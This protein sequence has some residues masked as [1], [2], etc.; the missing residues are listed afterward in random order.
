[1]FLNYCASKSIQIKTQIVAH[2]WGWIQN[3]AIAEKIGFVEN[4]GA[5]VHTLDRSFH[6]LDR[7]FQ[8]LSTVRS[9]A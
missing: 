8:G 6:A 2:F 7:P 3:F 1:M 4:F 9:D 5:P